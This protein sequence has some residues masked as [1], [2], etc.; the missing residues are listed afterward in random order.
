MDKETILA[1]A[2]K[3]QEDEGVTFAKHKGLANGYKIFALLSGIVIIFNLFIGQN[4]YAVMSLFWCFIATEAYASFQFTG[5]KKYRVTYL[6]AGIACVLFFV[7][8]ILYAI[9]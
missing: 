5:E 9:G 7:N 1:Q 2:Q 3:T 6:S 8:H 4:S